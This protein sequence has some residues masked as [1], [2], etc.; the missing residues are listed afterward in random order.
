MVEARVVS[1][2]I[3]KFHFYF[4]QGKPTGYVYKPKLRY[5]EDNEER[6]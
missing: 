6:L 5:N 3:R 1:K 2:N 4:A